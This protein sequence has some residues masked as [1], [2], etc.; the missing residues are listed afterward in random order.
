MHAVDFEMSVLG[1]A[2]ICNDN[3]RLSALIARALCSVFY[4]GAHQR[5]W[6][7]IAELVAVD[8]PVE[9][10]TVKK[11]LEQRDVEPT[12]GHRRD[13]KRMAG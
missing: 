12:P 11:H 5:I 8:A 9:L 4:L 10:L 13:L 1:A 6:A 3:K 7:A 2:I